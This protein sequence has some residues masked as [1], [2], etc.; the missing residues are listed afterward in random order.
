V[1]GLTRI[2]RAAS[3]PGIRWVLKKKY[4]ES[5]LRQIKAKKARRMNCERDELVDRILL[6]ND[7]C[8]AMFSC[9]GY[10]P[11]YVLFVF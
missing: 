4:E 7:P 5:E 9:R 1:V 10:M 11:V 6:V 2:A 8:P 3:A